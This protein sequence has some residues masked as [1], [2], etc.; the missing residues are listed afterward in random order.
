MATFLKNFVL[1]A[2]THILP[3]GL[4]L[5]TGSGGTLGIDVS[6]A[7]NIKV[8][9]VDDANPGSQPINYNVYIGKSPTGPWTLLSPSM[10][11]DHFQNYAVSG[12]A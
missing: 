5:N 8:T 11:N 7:N 1:Q 2:S 12:V 6:V 4:T 10:P 9:I 3:A